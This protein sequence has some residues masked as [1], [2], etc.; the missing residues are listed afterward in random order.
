MR[1]TSVLTLGSAIAVIVALANPAAAHLALRGVLVITIVVVGI[2]LVMGVMQ[3]VPESPFRAEPTEYELE[4]A[5]LPRD[6]VALAAEVR[7]GRHTLPTG[8]AI[9][10]GR[11]FTA[12]LRIEHGLSTERGADAAAIEALLSP[13]ARNLLASPGAVRLRGRDLDPLLHEL[14]HL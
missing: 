7:A 12:T 4:A 14:E 9:R 6:L 10:L 11:L 3:R 5:L 13:T 1:Y 8:V 2:H